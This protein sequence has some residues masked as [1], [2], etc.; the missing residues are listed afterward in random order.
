ME[1]EREGGEVNDA[2]DICILNEQSYKG[3]RNDFSLSNDRM[4]FIKKQESN[5]GITVKKGISS[6]KYQWKIS[7]YNIDNPIVTTGWFLIGVQLNKPICTS[8]D[9]YTEKETF[10]ISLYSI[11]SGSAGGY[12]IE[13]KGVVAKE[14]NLKVKEGEELEVI[15][16][17]SKGIFQLISSTFNHSISIPILQQNQNYYL[18]FAPHGASFSLLSS[19][20]LK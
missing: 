19:E 13:G 9:S 11:Q 18:H 7:Y 12:Y 17:C 5:C 2:A 6:G 16:D 4:Q 1:V 8:P 20:K 10:G 14:F 3:N 15:V